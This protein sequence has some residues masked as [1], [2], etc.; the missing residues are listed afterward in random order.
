MTSLLVFDC[1]LVIAATVTA[2]SQRHQPEQESVVEIEYVPAVV[3]PEPK[4]AIPQDD[5]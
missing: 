3:P 4:S 5:W 2:T 1:R